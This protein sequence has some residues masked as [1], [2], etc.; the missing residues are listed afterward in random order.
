MFV[1]SAARRL[2]YANPA[3]EALVGRSLAAARGMRVS[4]RRSAGDL[5]QALAPPAEVWAGRPARARRAVPPAETGPPWWDVTFVPL[6]AGGRVTGVVGFVVVAGDAGARGP[7]AKLSAAVADLRAQV[8]L[9]FSLDLIAGPSLGAERLAAQVRLAIETTAPVWIC[10]EPG[11]GKET[12]ARV[13][14]HD[15]PTRERAFWGVECGGLPAALIESQLFG[16]GG[17]AA[18]DRLGTLY[19]KDPA[20]LPRDLQARIA[21]LFTPRRP[22][23]P[24]LICGAARPAADAMREGKLIPP[25]HTALSV[26]ELTVPPLRDRLDDLS[27]LVDRLL[28]RGSA[29][30]EKPRVAD[31]VWPVLRVHDWPGNV[32]ELGDI[33][34][35]AVGKAGTG[36]VN[37]DHLPRYLRDRFLVAAAP[38]RPEERAWTLDAVL[39]AVEKRLIELALR[40]AG[41]SQTVAAERLGVFRTRL[42]RR[43]EALGI[44]VPPQPPKARKAKGT[45]GPAGANEPDGA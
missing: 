13:I 33:L 36:P 42:W 4:S 10:G 2:R 12:L 6:A 19:L 8:A 40:Q 16:K 28:E 11:A 21:A 7:G 39:E 20:A 27:R 23:G 3:W 29:A 26:L 5:A 37:K 1:V 9:G 35:R 22:G 24:R 38:V 25:F 31:D 43:M 14:H 34:V 44:P 17:L 30:G 41:G 45:G 32:R 18:S 15:G